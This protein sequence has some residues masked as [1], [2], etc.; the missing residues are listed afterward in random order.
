MLWITFGVNSLW[1]AMEL[2]V[3]QQNK[4]V[5]IVSVKIHSSFAVF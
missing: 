2:S 3:Y 4:T 5:M 1:S